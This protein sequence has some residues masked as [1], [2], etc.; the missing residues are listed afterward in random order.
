MDS[1]VTQAEWENIFLSEP[2]FEP[3][4]LGWTMDASA[5]SAIPLLFSLSK[6]N[7][8]LCFALDSA[9]EVAMLIIFNFWIYLRESQKKTI[10]VDPL[11][12]KVFVN[13]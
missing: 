9:K 1:N 7:L 6:Y 3:G 13:G 2:R 8:C 12:T 10:I 4:P 5:N 11:P